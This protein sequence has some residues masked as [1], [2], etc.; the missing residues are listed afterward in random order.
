MRLLPLQLFNPPYVPTPDEEVTRG[1]IAASWAGGFR[2]RLVINRLLAQVRQA[3]TSQRCKG[4]SIMASLLALGVW[5][6]PQHPCS[7]MATC[8]L[9]TLLHAAGRHIGTCGRDADGDDR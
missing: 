3:Q 5:T 9:A 7:V 6:L 1:G 4:I 8:Q 2:G